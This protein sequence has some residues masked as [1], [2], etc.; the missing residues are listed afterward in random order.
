MKPSKGLASLI[1]TTKKRTVI[2]ITGLLL[3]S[4]YCY[5][6]LKYCLKNQT[7]IEWI[8]HTRKHYRKCRN[9]ISTL[10]RD[11]TAVS[12]WVECSTVFSPKPNIRRYSDLGPKLAGNENKNKTFGRTL[13]ILT[14][15][16]KKTLIFYATRTFL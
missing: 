14:F 16:K 9:S 2:T 3:L 8:K 4:I 11:T 1:L 5:Y 6:C 7:T 12:V 10:I 15:W 13:V